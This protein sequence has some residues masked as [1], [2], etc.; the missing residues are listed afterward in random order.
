MAGGVAIGIVIYL[1][2]SH[3]RPHHLFA[4]TNG[5]ILCWRRHRQPAGSGTGASGPGLPG[6]SALW[7]TSVSCRPIRQLGCCC[8]PWPV[9]MRGRP[10][11]SLPS[12]WAR[13]SSSGRHT[14]G[15]RSSSARQRSTS[16]RAR[17][18]L[19]AP[20]L[21]PSGVIQCESPTWRG[22][23]PPLSPV[24]PVFVHGGAERLLYAPSSR[25]A[26]RKSTSSGASKSTRTLQR[27]ARPRSA[28]AGA[29]PRGG[30]PSCT[31]MAS[32]PEV[33]RIRR[34]GMG[35]PI[36]ADSHRQVPGWTSGSCWKWNGPRTGPR[37]YELTW[38]VAAIGVGPVQG[39]LN[40]LWQ[41]HV[42]ATEHF[43]TEL[44][45]QAQLNTCDPEAGLGRPGLRRAVPAD[46]LVPLLRARAS[47]RPGRSAK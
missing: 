3:I 31:Q 26:R 5:F 47:D 32:E 37:G 38:P 46:Q 19:V 42:R 21:Q 39:N 25:K 30:S 1:G 28:S 2:L 35:K 12:M 13:C 45:Y 8:T 7:D 11:C 16:L 34:V 23:W 33:L 9:T 15:A 27:H 18:H 22:C 44:K 24:L 14:P 20:S 4:V 40:L 6:P 10:G 41:K 36:P 43:D 17:G 29:P